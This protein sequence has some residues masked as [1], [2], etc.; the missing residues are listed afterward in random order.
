M[1]EPCGSREG[2][3]GRSVSGSPRRV[4]SLDGLRTIAVLL[5]VA[6]HVGMPGMA[7][8]YLGVDVFFVLSGFLITTLLLKELSSTGRI[9]LGRFWARRALRLMPAAMLVIAAVVVWAL[10]VAEP[11]RRPGIGADA[12]WSLLYVGN[13]RFISSSSYFADDGTSSPL[14]H[15]WSLAVEEQFYVAWPLLLMLVCTLVWRR[16][17]GKG[18]VDSAARI[19]ADRRRKAGVVLATGLLALTLAVASAIW[20]WVLYDP[21][22]PERAYMG[23]DTKVFEPLIGA[24]AAALMT[25]KRLQRW[26]VRRYAVLT[27]SGLAGLGLGVA[28]LGGP[29]PVYFAGGAVAFSVCCAVLVA[30]ATAGGN[31]SLIARTLGLAPVAYL[32][33]IS[34]GIYL[35]HWPVAVWLLP[36]P[37]VFDPTRAVAVVAFT[38]ALAS[39]SYHL[40]EVPIRTGALTRARPRHLLPLGATSLAAVVAFSTLLG[41]TTLSRLNPLSVSVA[42]AAERSSVVVVGDSVMSR[43]VPSLAQTASARGITVLNGARGGCPALTVPALDAAGAPWPTAPAPRAYA[44]IRTTSSPRPTRVSSSGGRG[45]NSL[46]DSPTTAASCGPGRRSSGRLSVPPSPPTSPG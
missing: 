28:T 29:S 11:Y 24:A 27:V 37:A 16:A 19:E 26:V 25:R 8:G 17:A 3:G 32:G 10:F 42:S 22:A 21:A 34:Y 5:V 44:H 9:D 38:I 12:L 20:L 2:L 41:G 36:D 14:L 35:W 43:L 46:T 15:V 18:F 23:T 7:G 40:V 1:R 45:T 4:D 6:F 31:Q 39:V 13:W 30:A 33:R